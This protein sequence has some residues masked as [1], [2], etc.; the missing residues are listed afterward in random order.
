[1]Y[2]NRQKALLRLIQNE[3]LDGILITSNENIFYFTGAPFIKDSF[4]K[5][6]YFN[7][8]GNLY[9]I[10]SV[11]DY[12]EVIDS[13][14]DVEIIKAEKGLFEEI[15]KYMG[16]K[17]GF[18]EK[19]MNQKMYQSLIKDYELIPI[20]DYIEKMREIKDDKEVQII[21][22]VQ[23]LTEKALYEAIQ[24]FSENMSE[25]E[26]AAELE[27]FVRKL[28]AETYAFDTIV[29]SG[30]RS[31]YPHGLPS[32][33]RVKKGEGVIIDIGARFCGYCSDITRTIFFGNPTKKMMEVYEAV[34]NAQE[35]AI[36]VVKPG[37][38]CKDLD[39]IARNVLKEYGYDEYFIHGL[40]HGI[41]ISVHEPPYI[42]RKGEEEIKIGN[43]I[44]IEPGV[45]IPK[46]GGVRI[47]DIILITEGGCKNLTEFSKEL[48]KVG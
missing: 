4:C 7:K 32:K 9:L 5:I 40:G 45:Y 22:E 17:I 33:K 13:V 28:G 10:V 16:R 20:S 34:L 18:E 27:Y 25:L 31:A 2:K 36:K 24:N 11:I 35:E 3:D 1:M 47:E 46:I 29:A 44:T 8:D 15:K 21:K 14:S 6:L 19:V 41:G 43:V 37:M 23:K 39:E 42:N 48:Y 38:K 30:Y 12:Q 26:L